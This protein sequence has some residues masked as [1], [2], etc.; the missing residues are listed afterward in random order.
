MST[1][2]DLNEFVKYARKSAFNTIKKNPARLLYGAVDPA[3]T[4]A[5]NKVLGRDDKPILNQLGSPQGGGDL[6]LSKTG[7]VYKDARKDGVS[8]NAVQRGQTFFGIGDT[9]AGFYGGS[10]AAGA[11]GGGSQAGA[12]SGLGSGA[13]V[14]PDGAGLLGTGSESAA[15]GAG[16]GYSSAAG[17]TV[18]SQFVE[19]AASIGSAGGSVTGGATSSNLIQQGQGLLAPKQEPQQQVQPNY[20]TQAPDP[21][22]QQRARLILLQQMQLQQLRQKPNKTI[23]DYQMLNQADKGQGLLA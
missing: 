22:Q 3:S 21:Q 10:A 19:P 23:E 14:A 2:G 13:S 12:G 7:G 15:A 18:A 6:G 9:I 4:W 1:L 8:S 17:P 5:W 20:P 11:L 16:A